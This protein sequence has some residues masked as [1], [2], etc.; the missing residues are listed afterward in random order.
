MAKVVFCH[1]SS[2]RFLY[3]ELC[4]RATLVQMTSIKTEADNVKRTDL[5]GGADLKDSWIWL[6][7]SHRSIVLSLKLRFTM[8]C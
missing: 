8:E 2:V 6:Q 1:F 5:E 3:K 4:A 7:S